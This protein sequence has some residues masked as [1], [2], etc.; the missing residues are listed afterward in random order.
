M[1]TPGLLVAEHEAP[2]LLEGQVAVGEQRVIEDA[3]AIVLTHAPLILVPQF[4]DLLFADDLSSRGV[5]WLRVSLDLDKGSRLHA[6]LVNVDLD[7]LVKVG[8]DGDQSTLPFSGRDSHE[9]ADFRCYCGTIAQGD[10]H[11]P[12]FSRPRQQ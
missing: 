4:E 9:T 10:A 5:R 1:T 11:P 6:H 3:Q 7:R 8:V 12:T 2:D